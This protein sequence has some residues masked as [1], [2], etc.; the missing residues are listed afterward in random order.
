MCALA[1][2]TKCGLRGGPQDQSVPYGT[3]A[4]AF[5]GPG[6]DG[7]TQTYQRRARA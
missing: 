6:A 7:C 3:G 4:L 1:D 5:A 2:N